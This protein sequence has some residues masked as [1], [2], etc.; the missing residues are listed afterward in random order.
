MLT[1]LISFVL[2]PKPFSSKYVLG[3]IAVIV[4]LAA[5]HELQRRKGGDVQ[6]LSAPRSTKEKAAGSEVQPL[7]SAEDVVAPL[8]DHGADD[9][10]DEEMY[11]FASSADSGAAKGRANDKAAEQAEGASLRARA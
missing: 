1:V 4:S 2:Y 5:T 10:P 9:I 8:A 6:Q 3:G 7:A 11:V